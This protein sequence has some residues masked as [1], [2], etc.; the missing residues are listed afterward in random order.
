M[1]AGRSLRRGLALISCLLLVACVGAHGGQLSPIPDPEPNAYRDRT[2]V[3]VLEGQA[4]YYSDSLAGNE[5]SN[6]DIYDPGRLTAASRDLPFGS[7]VRVTRR[8][9]GASVIV[10]VN[11]RGPFGNEKR[12]L[13]LSRAAA[14]ELHMIGRGVAPVRAEVLELGK[15]RPRSRADR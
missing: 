4:T 15:A 12:I 6:G 8:D 7:I 10:R 3:V 1:T 13:D 14:A 11:D 9:T 2:P 5:T